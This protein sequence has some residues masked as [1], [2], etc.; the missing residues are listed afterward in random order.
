MS[1]L[2][3][4]L[5]S[6][7]LRLT[8]KRKLSK[9]R[10]ALEVR[11]VYNAAALKG[12]SG[13]RYS[14]TTLSGVPGEWVEANAAPAIATLLYLH[15]G[16][17]VAMSSQNYRAL[18][19]LFA[20]RGYK[21]F[22][23]NFRLAPEHPFP[24]ALDDSMSVFRALRATTKGPIVVAGDSS[25]GGLALSL[26][27]SLRD[28][29]EVGPSAACLY[30]PWTDLV[31]EGAG[32]RPSVNERSDAMLTPGALAINAAAYAGQRNLDDPLISPARG[33][34]TDL[35]PLMIFA[36]DKELLLDQSVQL[37]QSATAANV[38][39]E[40][41]IYSGMPHAWP[42]LGS[43]LPEGRQAIDDSVQFFAKALG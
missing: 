27:M 31:G 12:P 19:G 25:G 28:L 35:P 32:H 41:R 8:M 39:V 34:L 29:A 26:M 5:V 11:D 2:R 4:F 24:A 42:A 43:L 7:L 6:S 3:T 17:Y 1:N 14:A 23:P 9:C 16:G 30:S 37:V 10:T 18:T 38:R 21:T 36:S 20:L 22:V 13:V 40:S 33:K 15:G